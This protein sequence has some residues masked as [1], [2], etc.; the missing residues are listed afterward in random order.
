MSYR[1]AFFAA[2]AGLRAVAF[3]VDRLAVNF[4]LGDRLAVDFLVLAAAG[5]LVVFFVAISLAPR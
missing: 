4:F 3:L 5:F 2:L 1:V